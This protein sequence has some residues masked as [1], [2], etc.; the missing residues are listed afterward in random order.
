MKA[1]KVGLCT[2]RLRG[3]QRGVG[4]VE[5]MISLA[6]AAL[7]LVG[8]AA[9]FSATSQA[10]AANDEFTR[11][12]QA[13]RVSTNQ[14]MSLCRK[15]KSGVLTASTLELT[16]PDDTKQLYALNL[17]TNKLQVTLESVTPQQVYTLA[18]NVSALKFTPGAGGKSITMAVTVKVGDNTVVLN[19]SAVPRRLV[20]Y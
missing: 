3:R 1:M 9:A 16:M 2:L 18:H 7:L 12:T 20:Q 11:A 6:I 8:V 5:L 13:A 15:C 14:V 10:V 19:G 17:A 4:M